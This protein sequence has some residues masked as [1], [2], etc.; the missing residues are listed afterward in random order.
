MPHLNIPAHI[1]ELSPDVLRGFFPGF[2]LSTG[3]LDCFRERVLR[4]AHGS[5]HELRARYGAVRPDRACGRGD[6]RLVWSGG[7]SRNFRTRRL[8]KRLTS[9][10]RQ[11]WT[12]GRL[13]RSHHSLL[14]ENLALCP[15][16]SRA[17]CVAQIR[18][19]PFPAV[20]ESAPPG[21]PTLHGFEARCQ[22]SRHLSPL[23]VDNA[24]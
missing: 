11:S 24:T 2:R 17:V 13:F 20:A 7:T 5:L 12:L 9:R 14:L 18:A 23:T 15:T 19:F 3:C 21:V 10:I 22:S 8:S 6:C 4:S 1:N 16:D